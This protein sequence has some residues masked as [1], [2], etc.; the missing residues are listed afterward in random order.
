MATGK[1]GGNPPWKGKKGIAGI[2]AT[3]GP[4]DSRS[5]ASYSPFSTNLSPNITNYTTPASRTAPLSYGGAGPLKAMGNAAYKF[6][7]QT[8]G[9]SPSKA[10]I[11]LQ[12]L[13]TSTPGI[14]QA[15][16]FGNLA[17]TA[18]GLLGS[19]SGSDSL[20]NP[21]EGSSGGGLSAEA[22]QNADTQ[23]A[24]QRISSGIYNAPGGKSSGKGAGGLRGQENRARNEEQKAYNRA[25][26]DAAMKYDPTYWV[27]NYGL[28]PEQ[29]A[30]AAEKYKAKYPPEFFAD[31]M[32]KKNMGISSVLKDDWE[33]FADSRGVP[34]NIDE[35]MA[36]A[37]GDG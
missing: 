27:T 16:L 30:T 25:V 10:N 8:M 20:T 29:A 3:M 7:T 18:S 2:A 19:D 12:V 6:L 26:K 21:L 24:L 23:G 15:K 31:I 32:D 33:S 17:E 11:V 14:T 13:S 1:Y 35:L 36:A 28:S 37:G 5:S 22:I 9:M 4:G 34:Y